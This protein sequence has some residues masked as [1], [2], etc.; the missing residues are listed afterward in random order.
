MDVTINAVYENGVFR[1]TEPVPF[2]E[3]QSVRVTRTAPAE[4][5]P[6]RTPTPDEVRARIKAIAAMPEEPGGDKTVTSMN[7]DEV[8]Y[9]RPG[10]PR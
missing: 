8:L 9:G 7:V 6:A 10:G 5:P 3:G 4:P 1:P 2:A